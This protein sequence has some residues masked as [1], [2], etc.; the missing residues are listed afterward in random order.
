MKYIFLLLASITSAHAIPVLNQNAAGN[1]TSVTIWPDHADPNQFYFAPSSIRISEQ[2]GSPRFGFVEYRVHCNRFGRNCQSKALV[3]S[4]LRADFEHQELAD[5]QALIRKSRPQARFSVIP[6]F[7]GEVEFIE[8]V[9]HFVDR[10]ECVPRAASA[11]DDIPCSLVLNRKGIEAMKPYLA[12]GK[13]IPLQ[14]T[15]KLMGVSL[16][17]NNTFEEMTIRYGIAVNLGGDE[18]INHPDLLGPNIWD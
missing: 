11:A 16:K 5:A 2:N 1:A 6:M 8:T 7:E 15:Y 18:L 4:I 3:T 13:V 12:S 14:F 10:H 9:A 17:P